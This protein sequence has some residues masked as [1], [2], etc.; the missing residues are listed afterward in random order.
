MRRR[1]SLLILAGAMAAGLTA[2]GGGGSSDYAAAAASDPA[3]TLVYAEMNPM[4]SIVGQTAAAFKE[5]AEELSGG[6]I[7]IDIQSDGVLGTEDEILDSFLAGDSTP[8]D[9]CRISAFALSNRGCDKAKLLSIPYTWESR[10]HWWSFANSDLAQEF[11]KEP[12]TIGLPI[13]GIFY[14]EE[15][16]RN[17]F[18]VQ[19]VS[20]IEDFKGLKIRV[21]ND[22]VMSSV[23]RSLGAE[24]VDVPFNELYNALQAGTADGAEQPI[25]NYRANAFEEVAGNLILD[26]HTLGAVQVVITDSAWG[27]LTENQQKCIEEAG[28]YAQEFNAQLSAS[29]EERALE[30]LRQEGCT[31]VEVPDK[32]AW[33]DACASV[34]EENT[35]DQAALYQ[36]LKDCAE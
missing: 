17:F 24:P 34:I 8:A 15:G 5:K 28:K 25:A 9:L 21:S 11:L 4:D 32:Q 3:V 30:E 31:V 35:K 18:T 7:T 12:Q 14:G 29:E 13:R 23:V 16:F 19:E 36:K 26:G 6:T 2:C 1:L 10:D 22:T 27:K 33:A 20:G